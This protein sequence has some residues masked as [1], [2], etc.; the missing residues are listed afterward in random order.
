MIFTGEP[1]GRGGASLHVL[2]VGGFAQ[3]RDPNFLDRG[4]RFLHFVFNAVS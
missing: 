3:K 2:P 1:R 4:H